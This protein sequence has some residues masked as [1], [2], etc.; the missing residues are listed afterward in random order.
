MV[1]AR[2]LLTALVALLIA[3]IGA[4]MAQAGPIGAQLDAT[5][6]LPG[7]DPIDPEV[8]L[9]PWPNDFFTKADPTTATGKRLNLLPTSTPRNVAG[10]PIDVTELN[11]HDGFS[12]GTAIL[13][14]VYGLGTQAAFDR[15]GLVPEADML[16][17]FDTSQPAVV[18]DAATGERQLIWAEMDSNAG[19]EKDRVLIIRPGRNWKEG[20][21]YIVALR[22]LRFPDGS[23]IQPNPV[24][25]LYRDR[26]TTLDPTVEARR[27]HMEQLFTKLQKAGISRTSL[28]QAW[29]FTVASE[30]DRAER[31]LTMRDQ[32]FGELGDSNLADLEVAGS[33]PAFTVSAVTDEQTVDGDG[34]FTG[35]R[36][37]TGTFTVPCFLDKPG[38]VPGSR[39]AFAG[40][41]ATLPTRIPGNTQSATFTCYL[42]MAAVNGQTGDTRPSLYGHGLLGGQGEVGS[43]PQRDM[44]VEQNMTYCATDWYGFAT[45]DIGSVGATLLDASNFPLMADR[46]QQGMLDF[47]F[48]G[49]LAIHPQGFNANP[50]FKRADGTPIIDTTRLYYDGNS[51]GGIMGGALV[52]TSPDIERGALGVPAM[53]YSTLLQRSVDFEFDPENPCPPT[54][55]AL[56]AEHLQNASPDDPEG[57]LEVVGFSYSCPLYAAYP[58]VKERQLIFSLMQQL[59]DRGEANGY[60]EHMTSDPLPNTPPHEVLMH[61]ALGDHQVANVA[62]EVQARTIGAY[63]RAN[64]VDPGR[65]FSKEHGYGIPTITSYPFAGSVY[66]I[67]D[68]GPI[69]EGGSRGNNPTPLGN[70]PNR[71]GRD[72][73]GDPRS[74]DAAQRQKSAFFQPGGMV[75]DECAGGPCHSRG[76]MGAT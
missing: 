41:T 3:S 9:L 29:D 37:V 31:I 35:R 39:M 67:W 56:I 45:E 64:I 33:A 13:T 59:W 14:K 28:Y 32:A 23:I 43:G 61:A 36:K 2:V 11:R 1:S 21:R 70:V 34:K 62:A 18:I 65:S 48:L 50:A 63:R 15:T 42:P 72:P 60:A 73:H 25:K 68:S 27:P 66:E 52:A 5:T 69:R 55:P 51:Q 58:V 6:S 19:R 12:P 24:F 26:G 40:P 7:C 8:C 49:R 4:P 47:M 57:F 22:N 74:T 38:C 20:H 44:V 71:P 76:W 17:A 75:V 54:D 53:N 46:M 30:R 10:K 16:R